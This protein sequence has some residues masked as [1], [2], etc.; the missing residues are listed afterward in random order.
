MQFKLNEPINYEKI[1]T[2]IIEEVKIEKLNRIEINQCL[3]FIDQALKE[4][5]PA[6]KKSKFLMVKE[7]LTNRL[8]EINV[9]RKF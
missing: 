9:K 8:A 2:F 7:Q 5:W 4:E 6:K 1:A 3:L